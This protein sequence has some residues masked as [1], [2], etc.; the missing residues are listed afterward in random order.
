MP[1]VSPLSTVY[2]RALRNAATAEE[3]AIWQR[4]RHVRPRFTRQLPIGPYSVDFACRTRRVAIE[5]DGG[6][7]LDA[8]GYDAKRTA[9]LQA[10]GWTVVRFWNS[11]VRENADGV[12]AA[13]LSAVEVGLG[14]THPRPLPSREGS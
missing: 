12:A 3:R 1:R 13:I 10:L 5:L 11:D 2:A 14:P 6:Q 8:V 7:H 4:I 9:F